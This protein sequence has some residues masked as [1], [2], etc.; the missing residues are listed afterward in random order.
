MRIGL[1][2]VSRP[3]SVPSWVSR[4]FSE[5]E[6]KNPSRLA[7]FDGFAIQAT[8]CFLMRAYLLR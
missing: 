8:S 5:C 7:G 3:V 1:A 6:I 4:S 2:M